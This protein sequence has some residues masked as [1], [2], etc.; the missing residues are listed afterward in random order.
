MR[1]HPIPIA[2]LH[3][4]TRVQIQPNLL[5]FY[6]PSPKMSLS[7]DERPRIAI[8]RLGA[9]YLNI[10]ICEEVTWGDSTIRAANMDPTEPVNVCFWNE[11]GTTNR[12]GWVRS[13]KVNCCVSNMFGV[14]LIILPSDIPPV[15][16]FLYALT[17]GNTPF[18]EHV[19]FLT[20]C[21]Q[22]VIANVQQFCDTVTGLVRGIDFGLRYE[23][24]EYDTAKFLETDIPLAVFVK[25]TSVLRTSVKGLIEAFIRTVNTAILPP[26]TGRVLNLTGFKSPDRKAISYTDMHGAMVVVAGLIYENTVLADLVAVV[27]QCTY[28]S[29]LNTF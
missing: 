7:A 21:E 14:F 16:I 2:Q 1:N 26:S 24:D 15:S 10:E 27:T 12:P 4:S 17:D 20:V 9:S 19:E 5:L 11:L 22:K 8:P 13:N 18:T 3:I 23:D 29:L 25:H 28:S 6:L